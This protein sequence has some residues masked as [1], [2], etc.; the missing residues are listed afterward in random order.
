MAVLLGADRKNLWTKF[1][2]DSSGRWEEIP[3]NKTDARGA[4]DEMDS[5]CD[6]FIDGFDTPPSSDIA[7]LSMLQRLE[8]IRDNIE[9]R[10]EKL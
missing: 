5:R 9:R 10:M 7:Q 1:M 3:L 8:L 6:V 4:I 2:S